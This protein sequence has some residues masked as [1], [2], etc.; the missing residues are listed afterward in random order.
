MAH[1]AP[2]TASEMLGH[3]AAAVE[4]AARR[5]LAAAASVDAGV[6]LTVTVRGGEVESIEHHRDTSLAVTV[7]DGARKGSATTN[8]LRTTALEETV[9]AAAHIARHA[10]PDPYAGLVDPA[11][12]AREHPAL[13]L[14]H[15]WHLDVETA[16]AL[17]REAEAAARAVSREIRQV[18]ESAVSEYRGIHAYADTQGFRGS[19]AATRHGQSCVVVAERDGA[20]QRGFWFTVARLAAELEAARDVGRRAGERTVARLGARK[21]TTRRAPVLFEARAAVSLIGHLV[22][23]ASGSAL[24]REAS[25]LRD[26]AGTAIFPAFLDIDEQPHLPR[27]LGSAPFDAEGV[28]TR[29]RR[30]VAGGVLTGYLLDGYSARRLRLPPTG[31]AGGPHNLIVGDRGES[32]ADLVRRLDTGLI[33]TELMGFGVNLLTGDYSRGASGFWVEGGTVQYPVEEVTIAGNLREMFAGVVA[34]GN[35][36]ELRGS[37]RTGSILLGSMTVAGD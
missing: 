17:A 28:A 35:D 4:R 15:P 8:D 12:L 31:H 24:Y 9:A 33:V 21:L 6:G 1:A 7:Y 19:F 16:S 20:M 2:F 14:D 13:D 5:G 22:G 25:F 3:A 11:C 36:L 23:A 37:T 26:A 10:E 27:A 29:A 30:L 34:T 32:Y 18:D